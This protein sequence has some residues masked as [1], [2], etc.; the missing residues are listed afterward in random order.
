[1][2]HQ[3]MILEDGREIIL[4]HYWTQEK[5]VA[6]SPNVVDFHATRERPFPLH[7]TTEIDVVNCPLCH[8]TD[9]FKRADEQLAAFGRIRKVT[10]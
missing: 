10:G 4:I 8:A 3:T 5:K 7:R 9:E 1:M 6:C 2:D